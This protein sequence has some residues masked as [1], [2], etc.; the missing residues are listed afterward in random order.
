MARGFGA[1]ASTLAIAAA[2][3]LGLS[4]APQS[5]ATARDYTQ[6]QHEIWALAP[7][8][9]AFG[10]TV[11]DGAHLAE[12]LRALQR[13]ASTGPVG[14][15]YLDEGIAAARS[16]L[17][18]DP[19]D[20]QAWAQ[21]GI[22]LSAPAGFFILSGEHKALLILGALDAARAGPFLE[23]ELAK[24]ND[25]MAP[26][27]SPSGHWLVCASN[28]AAPAKS[29]QAS[30]WPRL[31]REQPAENLALELQLYLNFEAADLKHKSSDDGATEQYFAHSQGLLAGCS[32]DDNHIA[33]R[34]LYA[35]PDTARLMPY[36]KPESGTRT[37][38][39]MAT[40]ARAVGR[41]FMS[42]RAL[43]KLAEDSI[44]PQ[45]RA[46]VTG[47]FLLSTGLDLQK[48]V[49]DN[50]TGELLWVGYESNAAS[51]SG[52]LVIGTQD[53]GRSRKVMERLDALAS[54]GLVA[55]QSA[56]EQAGWKIRHSVDTVAGRP[57][58][59]FRAEPTGDAM[60][61]APGFMRLWDH[62]E[63]HLATV[64]GAMVIGFD[65]GSVEHVAASAGRTPDAFLSQLATPEA[66][67][68]FESRAPFVSWGL[69]QDPF[70]R[71]PKEKWQGYMSTYGAIHSELPDAMR[72]FYQLMDL[73][74][75]ATMSLD[76]S[77]DGVRAF[78][79]FTLL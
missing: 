4:C 25:Q 66:R 45:Q 64:P 6:K 28:Q 55:A 51:L 17:G 29:E 14:K 54:G 39:G 68:A 36:L 70:A 34:A 43:W 69:I 41:F 31:T 76:V 63:V 49:V 18:F 78:Y 40:D 8:D 20:V 59:V 50:L 52:S 11:A 57:S 10:L 27:C 35:N 1:K 30:L 73:L 71:L 65:R 33:I 47:G 79:Q 67:R 7:G 22:D 58:Y 12:R 38:L 15:K 53:D 2:G 9:A 46:S 62:V 26:R 37:L 21:Q 13:V 16:E 48:D 3:V 61:S 23:R 72:E 75:D 77:P 44:D 32:F 74:Y 19:L 60:A 56:I 5:T 24:P 42:P